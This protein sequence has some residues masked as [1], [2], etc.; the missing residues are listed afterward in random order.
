RRIDTL[1]RPL[2]SGR[3]RNDAVYFTEKYIPGSVQ[4]LMWELYPEAREVILVR[5][6]RDMLS[7]MFAFNEK[8]GIQ[9]FQR[10][11]AGSDRE[12]VVD[13]VGKSIAALL[14]DWQARSGR[15][16]VVRYEDLVTTPVETLTG[17]LQY[18]GLDSKELIVQAMAAC[19]SETTPEMEWHQTAES[20]SSSIGRWRRDLG[21]ELHAVAQETFG[22]ALEAFGYEAQRQFDRGAGVEAGTSTKSAIRQAPTK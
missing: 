11:R 17:I 4:P 6:F 19:A 18:L 1:Y 15:A 8:R 5:D 10:S 21:P 22:P 9:G 16:H 14:R 2:A 12:Y 13:T 7:S 20:S 3:D